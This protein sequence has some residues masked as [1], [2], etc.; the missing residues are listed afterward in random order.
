MYIGVDIGG[1][2]LKVGLVNGED[3]SLIG[4]ES[5]RFRIDAGI[6]GVA[7]DVYHSAEK[8]FETYSCGMDDIEGIGIAIPG[9]ISKDAT[10]VLHAHNLN[11]HNANAK[12]AIQKYFPGKEVV[13]G[14]DADIAALAE[15]YGGVFTGKKTAVLLTLGTGLGGGIILNGK[16]FRGGNANGTEPGHMIMDMHGSKC[17]CGQ[18]GCMETVCAA[19]WIKKQAQKLY[20]ENPNHPIHEVAK[21]IDEADAHRLIDL[22]K[23]G[24]PEANAIMEEYSDNLATAILTFINCLDPEVIGLGGG[25]SEAGDFLLDKVRKKVNERTFF[26][27]EYPIL[28]A[29]MG[30]NAGMVGAAMLAKSGY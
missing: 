3:G 28:K 10:T 8:L 22:A 24:N 23:D 15:L 9:S 11:F 19:T 4:K 29:A 21:T 30:N 25:V 18:T 20:E 2:N 17:T 16:I 14:N 26:D 6:E 5:T 7:E 27:F 12:E 13:L 1:T